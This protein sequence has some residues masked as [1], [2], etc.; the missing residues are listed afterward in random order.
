MS[1][2]KSIERLSHILNFVNDHSFPSREQ[3]MSYLEAK[4]LFPTERTFQRDLK[5][6]REMCFIELN[7][8]RIHKGYFIEVESRPD[9]ENWMHVFELFHTARIIND[10]IIRSSGNIDFIDFDR[11]TMHMNP[12]MLGGLLKAVLD[13]HLVSFKHYSYWREEERT[14]VIEPH[15]LKQYQNRWYVYGCLQDGQFRSFGIDRISE[16]E[17]LNQSFKPRLKHPKEVFD[18]VIGLVYENEKVEEVILSFDPFQGNYIKSLP[19]HTSQKILSD[20]E[21]EL[22][23]SIH[24]IPNYELEEQILKHGERVKVCKPEWLSLAIRDRLKEAFEQYLN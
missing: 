20:D 12:D 16:L 8:H 2:F 24:V 4:E 6:L 23:I 14:M 5:T 10:T 21:K 15:L 17:I 11:A 3:I 19:M 1:Q 13:R 22:R 18:K 9:F 7:Y